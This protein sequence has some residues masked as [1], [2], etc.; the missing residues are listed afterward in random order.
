MEKKSSLLESVVKLNLFNNIYKGKTV[1]ITGH[2]GFKGSW[3]AIWLNMLGAKV[4]GYALDPYTENDNFVL[5]KIGDKIIDIRG[6]LRDKKHL[7]QVFATHKPE[8]V[9]HL[10]AQPLVRL[11]YD[12]PV[13]TYEVN[14]MGSIN[15]LE[16]IRKHRC[17][18]VAVMIT[19]DKCYENKEQIWGYKET[20]SLGGYDPYSSSKGATEIAINSWRLS[21]FNP[22][23]FDLHGTAVASARAGNV[24][25]GGDWALNRIVPDC[26]RAIEQ[27][28]AIEI[29]SPKSTR[30]WEFV[31]EPLSGYLLLGAKMY[32][33]PTKFSEPWNFGPHPDAITTV[34]NVSSR[35]IDNFGKGELLD[36]SNNTL[37]HEATLLSLD[38][39]KS[40][41]Y[42]DWSPTLNI[43]ETIKMTVDWYKS[44]KTNNVYDLCVKQINDFSVKGGYL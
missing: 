2:T 12:I 38:I 8:F 15:V 9:F 24:I 33:N 27:N 21:F 23:D 19:T 39:T 40:K 3:L 36:V 7:D 30:P 42:L 26:I 20:D 14:L 10:A 5:S 6:D 32:T 35:I 4:V 28:K 11:S 16:A 22:K 31:L 17:T 18:K 44:Y 1:L 34:W 41:H 25:G 43:D 13:E 37:P 29:R